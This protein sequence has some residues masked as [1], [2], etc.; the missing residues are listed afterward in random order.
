MR[1]SLLLIS[2]C[3]LLFA[4]AAA[5]TVARILT[6]RSSVA[7][8]AN[9]DPPPTTH[10]LF[11]KMLESAGISNPSG[12]V[13]VS[14]IFG[15]NNKNIYLYIYQELLEK[16]NKAVIAKVA[17]SYGMTPQEAEAVIS[18]SIEPLLRMRG[19]TYTQERAIIDQQKIQKS[20][21][22]LLQSSQLMYDL[23][24][25]TAPTEIFAN[26][27]L[28]DSSFDLIQD[29]NQIEQVLFVNQE[30]TYFN[31]APFKEASSGK[32]SKK[33][34]SPPASTTPSYASTS[35]TNTS[36]PSSSTP[37]A[38]SAPSSPESP[39]P[40]V[41]SPSIISS[42]GPTEP[43]PQH[44]Y[45]FDDL[46]SET[47]DGGK[48][49]DQCS[50]D[51]PLDKALNSYDAAHPA[52]QNPS[53]PGAPSNSGSNPGS[54]SGSGA[55]APTGVIG[56][57]TPPQSITNTPAPELTV[58]PV[59]HAVGATLPDESG[60]D[61]AKDEELL[62]SFPDE[63][64]PG[65]SKIFCLKFK[66]HFRTYQAYAPGLSCIQCM[67]A[68]MSETMRKML[69]QS[70]TPNKL[71]GN[72][73]ESAKCKKAI[74]FSDM[75]DINLFLIPTPILTPNKLGPL[76]GHDIGVEWDRFA[77]TYYPFAQI[78]ATPSRVQ[79]EALA[80]RPQGVRQDVLLGDITEELNRQTAIIANRYSDLP[81]STATDSANEGY[82]QIIKEMRQMTSFFRSFQKIFADL[83]DLTKKICEK[84]D[85][86]D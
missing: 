83:V 54:G 75:L 70:L 45:T 23:K 78:G 25:V 86:N 47:Y 34:G 7:L 43:L 46:V 79:D 14:D 10:A 50:S 74:N 63:V 31:Q 26:G 24:M 42:A 11:T 52:S 19:N 55:S 13:H 81:T 51:A 41:P 84:K 38:P 27:T 4:S 44:T 80:N 18:G 17:A 37:S 62:A 56:T 69:S 49:V 8:A 66:E 60:C 61:L 57:V 77:K 39:S 33:T 48:P 85:I 65:K 67:V 35:S 2:I 29:L 82:Q 30:K 36:A 64:P 59:S 22:D 1:R 15:S 40:S 58:T 12:E 68:G 28:D 76:V 5:G 6:F 20:F 21:S 16:P 73:G 71:T 72:L 53:S 9:L 3:L 32:T